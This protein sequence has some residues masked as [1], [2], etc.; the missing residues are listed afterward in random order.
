MENEELQQAV[1]T[2]SVPTEDTTRPV[3]T[4]EA[5][6]VAD[7]LRDAV[8]E[9]EPST[10]SNQEGG[11]DTERKPSRAERR[12]ES[13]VDKLKQ[14]G[15]QTN[16]P[17][18]IFGND[19]IFT[20]EEI[21]S[22]S[23]DPGLLQQRLEQREQRVQ[24]QA[25]SQALAAID[26]RASINDHLSD[27]DSVKKEMGDDPVIDKLVARQY[28]ALNHQTD[29]RTGAKVFVPTVK[30]SEL[31]KELKEAVEA[32]SNAKA[33]DMQARVNAQADDQAVPVSVLNAPSTD[34]EGQATLDKALK[35]GTTEDWAA[36][37]KR[38]VKRS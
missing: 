25:T 33:A 29:P 14:T 8:T 9:S 26:Y 2:E 22:G 30:M 32:K 5:P 10:P 19:P 23:F 20:P 21:E 36:V 16:D 12:V 11:V 17:S 38:K 37:L 15:Q 7:T 34:L 4:E 24:Q 28:E 1:Q 31:Y 35:T 27:I 18:Q 3:S 13:L 6:S